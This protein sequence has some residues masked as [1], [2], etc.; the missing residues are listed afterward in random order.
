[1]SSNQAVPKTFV[2][3]LS[4]SNGG[5]TGV[6]G[7]FVPIICNG[8]GALYVT[9]APT[10]QGGG[11]IDEENTSRIPS[12]DGISATSPGNIVAADVAAFNYAFNEY[13]AT[14]GRF[15]RWRGNENPIVLTSAAR[16]A[17]VDSATFQNYNARGAHFVIN[18]S[19][20][21]A[22]PSIVVKIQGQDPANLTSFYDILVSSA[23]TTTGTTILKVYPGISTI[24][25]AAASDILPWGWRVRVE[26]ADTDS[27][28][29]S[30]AGN[31]VL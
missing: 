1:M 11:T 28:T 7:P 18:V 10:A 15:N 8:E 25:N 14:G 29:Y 21:T 9:T 4:S 23:I 16:T 24:A 3:G 20:I 30:V 22:T 5:A 12:S 13:Q 6:A 2:Y 17:T 31:L 27:I 19:A 26:H